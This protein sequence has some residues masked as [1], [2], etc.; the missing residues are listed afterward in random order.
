MHTVIA[1]IAM[2]LAASAQAQTIHKC[3]VDGKITYSEAPCERGTGTV[4]AV[5][6]APPANPE[7]KAALKRMQKE[8]GALEKERKAREARQEREDARHDRQAA[9]H[10]RR[11]GKLALERKWAD[12]DVRRSSPQSM[13]AA[14]TKARRAAERQALECR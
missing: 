7:S 11:C 1:A 2:L 8:A 10:R 5:P 4:L 14:R 12:E 9:D 13:E 3:T 6:D